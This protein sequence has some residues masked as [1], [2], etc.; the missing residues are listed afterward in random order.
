MS[1]RFFRIRLL[2]LNLENRRSSRNLWIGDRVK[3][4][5]SRMK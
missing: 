1:A 2:W 4:G 5:G 3:V